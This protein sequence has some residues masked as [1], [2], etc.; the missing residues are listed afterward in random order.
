VEA[1]QERLIWLQLAAEAVNP[2]GID[3]AVKSTLLKVVALTVI[4]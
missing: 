1:V 3:G 2:V 4:E